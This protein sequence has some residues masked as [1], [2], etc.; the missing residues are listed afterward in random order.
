MG[1][2]DGYGTI[3]VSGEALTLTRRGR[4]VIDFLTVAGTIVGLWVAIAVVALCE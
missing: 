2:V 4:F 3:T 1:K